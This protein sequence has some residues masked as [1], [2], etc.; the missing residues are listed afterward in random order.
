MCKC[1]MCERTADVM[2]FAHKY[3]EEFCDNNRIVFQLNE[4][5]WVNIFCR[6]KAIHDEM[7][8]YLKVV[9]DERLLLAYALQAQCSRSDDILISFFKD[10]D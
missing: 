10:S 8:S 6:T 7:M 5:D 2:S 4:E 3:S 1:E 9:S